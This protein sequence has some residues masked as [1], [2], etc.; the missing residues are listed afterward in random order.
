MQVPWEFLLALLGIV[1]DLDLVRILDTLTSLLLPCEFE[2]VSI[3][4][5][6]AGFNSSKDARSKIDFMLE[7]FDIKVATLEV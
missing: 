6:F 1:V 2:R 7:I 5:A 4:A 3:T